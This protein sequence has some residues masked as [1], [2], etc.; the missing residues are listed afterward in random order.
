MREELIQLTV[1][2]GFVAGVCGW[3]LEQVT[4]AARRARAAELL[5]VQGDGGSLGRLGLPSPEPSTL[6][7]SPGQR[8]LWS[9][10]L[11][12]VAVCPCVLDWRGLHGHRAAC[13]SLCRAPQGTKTQPAPG[14]LSSFSAS[15]GKEASVPVPV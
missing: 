7:A 15:W 12:A 10:S 4:P 2:L 1:W 9:P 8:Q 13:G 11:T 3:G 5:R 14:S 6:A